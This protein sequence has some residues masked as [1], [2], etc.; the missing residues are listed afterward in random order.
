MKNTYKGLFKFRG[1]EYNLEQL[2]SLY[3]QLPEVDVKVIEMNLSSRPE[4]EVEYSADVAQ[5][6]GD[7]VIFYKLE[8]KY[9]PLFG[10]DT[11]LDMVAAGSSVIKGRLISTPAL[12]KSRIV[13][14]VA[15][16]LQ[17]TPSDREP[18]PWQHQLAK[19]P[20]PK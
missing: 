6:M 19:Y 12:K 9:I 2:M 13:N 7:I 5:Q 16:H 18:A 17:S 20:Y 4:Y 8:G 1:H 10:E 14:V 11:F 15:T 3:A